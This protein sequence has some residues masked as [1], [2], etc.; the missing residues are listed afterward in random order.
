LQEYIKYGNGH[1]FFGGGNRNGV[2]SNMH[3]LAKRKWIGRVG[4][5]YL[6]ILIQGIFIFFSDSSFNFIHVLRRRE[7]PWFYSSL[8]EYISDGSVV[9]DMFFCNIIFPFQIF[10]HNVMAGDF[11]DQVIVIIGKKSASALFSGRNLI[12]LF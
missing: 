2:S 11:Y 9:I 6:V 8:G 10:F 5:Y 12:T 1:T 3:R 7:I 4:F